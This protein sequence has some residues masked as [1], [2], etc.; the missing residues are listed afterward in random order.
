VDHRAHLLT[1]EQH[2]KPNCPTKL[3]NKQRTVIKQDSRG[4]VWNTPCPKKGG[5]AKKKTHSAEI[6]A[7]KH[8]NK[9]PPKQGR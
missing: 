1:R 7:N 2:P 6:P 3:K 8:S 5:M 9:P 4:G